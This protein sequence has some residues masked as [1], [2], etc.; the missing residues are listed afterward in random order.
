MN[1]TGGQNRMGKN[2]ERG[3]TLVEMLIV[4]AILSI[5]TSLAIPIFSDALESS[6]ETVDT[7]NRRNAFDL[8]ISSYYSDGTTGVYY[9]DADTGTLGTTVPKAYGQSTAAGAMEDHTKM[10]VRCTI[11]SEGDVEAIWVNVNGIDSSV[12]P[13][14]TDPE[15]ALLNALKKAGITAPVDSTAAGSIK[16]QQILDALEADGLS[17]DGSNVNSWAVHNEIGY[18]IV[19]ITDVDVST[20]EPGTYVRMIR[21]NTNRKT[22]TAV[23]GLVESV[24]RDGTTYNAITA[25]GSS[26]HGY[27]E[28]PGQ[29][30]TTK[31][32]YAETV[33]I[34]NAANV[35]G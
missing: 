26:K 20:V 29:N 35:T 3:F 23:Y 11:S 4:V 25:D 6:R 24:T 14:G 19:W 30:S 21:Y 33:A 32:S 1:G 18:N 9:F 27:K 34:M 13:G 28:I 12:L 8:A 15:L 10:A 17:L 22:Y 16:R 5:L 7:A 31:K 2:S